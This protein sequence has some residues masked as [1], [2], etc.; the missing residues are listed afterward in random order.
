M[1]KPVA[2]LLCLLL[3]AASLPVAA[4]GE[5]AVVTTVASATTLQRG[6]ALTLTVKVENSPNVTAMLVA[7]G[8]AWDQT[9][10]EFVSA[11]WLIAGELLKDVDTTKLNAVFMAKKARSFDGDVL[12]VELKV[13]ETSGFGHTNLTAGAVFEKADAG[14]P[15]ALV[16]AQV[17]IV[18]PHD[19]Q[20]ADCAY[21]KHCT[22]C[23]MTQGE[24]L[25]HDYQG[26]TCSRCGDTKQEVAST[27]T[28]TIPTLLITTTTVGGATAGQTATTTRTDA[29]G[30]V[31]TDP[32]ATT[33]RTDAGGSVIT[34]PPATTTRTDASGSVITDPPTTT[35]R[36]D[37]GGSVITDPP[38]T[39]TRTDAN[40]AVITDPPATTTR[41]DA[42]GS[43]ITDPPTTTTRTDADGSVITD[44]PT[45]Q[46]TADGTTQESAPTQNAVTDPNGE[47][48]SSTWV[49]VLLCV[50]VALGIGGAVAAV[51]LRKKK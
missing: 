38:A 31:I 8:N 9:V 33:T 51:V 43:V 46:T 1:K 4:E 29:G 3:M 14:Y 23:G 22:I 36:T 45:T 44:P 48:D 11:K 18:C 12:Q 27:T 15:V 13:K 42:D 28:T 25:G 19:W 49:F 37:A 40:G 41:T 20:A 5:P 32:P 24:A 35:T 10:F 6:D 21:P 34:D 26:N 30:S 50:V 16:S 17:Q 7:M 2:I 47:E 39:T